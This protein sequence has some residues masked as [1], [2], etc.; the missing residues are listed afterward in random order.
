MKLG[1]GAVQM[2]CRLGIEA[3]LIEHEPGHA[4]VVM[5]QT[6]GERIV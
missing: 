3:I 2:K 6:K 4:S 1:I 5:A